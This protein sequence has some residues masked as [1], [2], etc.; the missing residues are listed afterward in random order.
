MCF[1]Y[2]LVT[3]RGMQD[4]V[5]FSLVDLLYKCSQMCH[6]L[7]LHYSAI[8]LEELQKYYEVFPALSAVSSTVDITEP[9]HTNQIN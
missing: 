1:F 6:F 8:I 5:P 9:Q 7:K 2:V 4:K 3:L